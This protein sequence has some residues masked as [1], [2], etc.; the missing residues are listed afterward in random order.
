MTSIPLEELFIIV[1]VLVD[2]WYQKKGKPYLQGKPGAKPDFTDSEVITLMLMQDFIPYPSETQYMGY[3]HANYLALFPKLV[4]QSQF[5][6]RAR[7]LRLLVEKLRQSWIQQ[8]AW[9]DQSNFLL[10]TKPVPV[11]GYKRNKHQSDFL[12]SANYGHCASRNLNYFGY[13]LVTISTLFG[14]PIFY[15]LVPANTDERRAAEA[16][17]THFI[18]CDIFGDKGFIG[19]AWQTEIFDQTGNLI[20]TPRRSNQKVQNSPALDHFLSSKR[21]RIEGVFHEVQD[22]GRNIERLLTKTVLGLAT[23]VIAKMTSHILRR[24]LLVDFGVNVQTFAV[25]SPA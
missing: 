14:V 7:N 1:Y 20:W 11:L 5:N 16:V 3:I 22:V 23:R 4:S 10:D 13:K 8:K 6:R 9:H 2:D 24:L 25:S 18:C 19:L 17:I 21:E 15:D 12:G